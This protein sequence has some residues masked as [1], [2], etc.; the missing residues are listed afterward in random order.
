MQLGHPQALWLLILLPFILLLC[1]FHL[2]R[3]DAVR[4]SLGDSSVIQQTPFRFPGLHR[5]WFRTLL[6]VI[7][8][9]SFVFALADPQVFRGMLRLPRGALDIVLLF[10]VSKSM[11]AEDYS[12]QSRLEKARDLARQLLSELQGNRVGVV[13]YAGNSFR[14]AELTEDSRALDFILEHWVNEESTGVGGS[15]LSKAIE[16]GLALFPHD[17]TRKKIMVLFSDGGTSGTPLE[18]ILTKAKHLGVSMASFGLGSSRASR[19]PRYDQQRRFLGYLE[20]NGQVLITRLNEA[21]LKQIASGTNGRYQ[22]VTPQTSQ[23]TLLHAESM[24]SGLLSR[25]RQKIFQLF[26]GVG[27]LACAMEVLVVRL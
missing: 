5:A 2:R 18:P 4:R 7:P 14:Q 12:K 23:V 20:R 27:L 3:Q 22:Q 11:M 8:F 1:A 6:L 19:I 26:L 10:D 25:D 17:S 16:T 9:V 24:I 13:S 15:D 21:P